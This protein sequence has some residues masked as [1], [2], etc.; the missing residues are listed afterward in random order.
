MGREGE[1]KCKPKNVRG[2]NRSLH[3][4]SGRRSDFIRTIVAIKTKIIRGVL[5]FSLL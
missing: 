2:G 3:W 4:Q 5:I 1:D